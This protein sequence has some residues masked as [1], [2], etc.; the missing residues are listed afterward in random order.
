METNNHPYPNRRR[1][2]PVQFCLPPEMVAR[3]DE[4]AKTSSESRST[5]V[6]LAVTEFLSQRE[7]KATA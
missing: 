3:L 6:R 1:V 4:A 2:I 7:R 5:L